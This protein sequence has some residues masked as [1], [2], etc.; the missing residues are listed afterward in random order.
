M[1][2][3][4]AGFLNTPLPDI[5]CTVPG[6]NRNLFEVLVDLSAF[7]E[8]LKSEIVV[9]RQETPE[10]K[11]RVIA[12]VALVRLLEVV[13]SVAILAA[14]GVREE[15]HSMFRIFLDAYFV[16]GNCCASADF[17]PVYF[18]TDLPARLKLL[19]AVAKHQTDLFKLV[20]E[21]ATAEA[22]GE[23]GS[24]IKAEKI[25]AFNSY[26]FACNVDCD[27]IYDSIY[28]LVSA[29]VHTTPRCLE[30]YVE[31]D[32]EGN[33]IR[34]MH[35]PDP[36]TT[37]RVIFDISW[38]FIKALRVVIELFEIHRSHELDDFESRLK[39]SVH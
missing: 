20:N 19:N 32:A 15:L 38:F 6:A 24:K 3:D 25:D 27:Q 21:Y 36:D 28:R 34:V 16:L 18:R 23:L 14:H 35:R 29:S 4:G 33:I 9:Q 26:L 5:G 17:I 37:D 1:K 13:Q 39:E 12:A 22:K 8:K 31:T 10:E 7:A 11:Q 30:H 2:I